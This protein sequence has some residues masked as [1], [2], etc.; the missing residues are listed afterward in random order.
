MEALFNTQVDANT[1]IHSYLSPLAPADV[2]TLLFPAPAEASFN[3]QADATSSTTLSQPRPNTE[4]LFELVTPS[5]SL[6]NVTDTSCADK[7]RHHL[8]LYPDQSLVETLVGIKV[9]GARV[10]FTGQATCLQRPN[11]PSIH[12]HMDIIDKY[13]QDEMATGRIHELQGPLPSVYFCSP[14]GLVPKKRDGIQTGWRM[15]F[16]LSHPQGRSVNDGIPKHFGT[17]Q[18]ESFQHAL[19]VIAQSGPNSCLLKKDLKAAFRRVAISSFDWHLFLFFWRGKYYID[20]H[21]PF[22]LRTS[23]RIYNLFAEAIHWVLQY[24]F[25]W[26]L[27]HYVDD[28][29]GVF[30]PN[31]DLAVKSRLFD[32]ICNDFD[33]PTEPKK[34]K[35]GTRVNHLGF[36]VDTVS[37]T[38]T[39]SHN[40][41]DR[42]IKLLH[43][44]ISCKTISAKSLETLL[45][46]LNHCCEVIPVGRPFLRHLFTALSKAGSAI[47]AVNPYRYTRISKQAR[48]DAL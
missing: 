11:H 31:T 6:A 39:L 16:D 40:K 42:A 32:E 20:T 35:M 45:G 23:P 2:N 14:L 30:P 47:T 4:Q 5:H 18:Y 27:S 8:R 46:F 48:R 26:S 15:I 1:I 38:A 19:S 29:L 41:R 28:F 9:H 21:L 3:A 44:V 13:I 37:M 25:G 12:N 7:I 24:S 10:G 22:G 33:F 43:I 17:L 36:E 34:D